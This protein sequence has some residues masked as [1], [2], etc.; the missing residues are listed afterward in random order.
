MVLNIERP[1]NHRFARSAENI[2]IVS[3]NVGEVPNVTI[4]RRYQELEI[5]YGILWRILYLDLYLHPYKIKLTQQLKPADLSQR[6]RYAER[7]LEHQS[8]DDNLSNKIFFSDEAH[9]TLNWYVNKQNYHICG[10]ENAQVIEENPLHP[11]KLTVWCVLWFEG[12]I[13]LYFCE[14]DDGTTVAVNSERYG[15]MIIDFFFAFY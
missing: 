13:G 10:S 3:E 12:I 5:F 2:A 14:N 11:E 4:P 9:F 6:R 1:V 15:H 7:L 8:V